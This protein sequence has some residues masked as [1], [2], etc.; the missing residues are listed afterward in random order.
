PVSLIGVD[1]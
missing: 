1:D